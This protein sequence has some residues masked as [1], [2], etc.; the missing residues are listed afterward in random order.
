MYPGFLWALAALAIPLILHLFYFRRYKKVYFSN[1]R[2]LR[3]VKEETSVRNR[4]RNL[5][6]LLARMLAIA[7]LV[8]AFAQP[9]IPVGNSVEK[10]PKAVSIFVDN[11]FSMQA[12]GEDLPLLDRARQ[13]AREIILAFSETD[14]FQV[15]TN[16]LTLGESK[17]LSRDEALSA[18]EDIEIS[19]EVTTINEVLTRQH[20]TV[21]NDFD[22]RLR[23]Y[24]LSDFQ[25]SITDI[26]EI[27]SS[28][29]VYLVP[30][31]SVQERN[32]SIDT[33][34][35]AEPVHIINQTSRIIVKIMNHSDD[36]IENIK[37]TISSNGQEKPAATLNIE[38]RQ[39]VYDT[40][41]VSVLQA[42]WH[43]ATLRITDFPVQ[44]DDAYHMTFYVK[45]NVRIL[46]IHNGQLNPRVQAAFANNDQYTLEEKPVGNL[47]Y[48]RF[49]TYDMIILDEVEGLSSG[50][51][52]ALQNYLSSGG[53]VLFFP[54]ADGDV[55]SY[56]QLFT[57]C[58]A[59][60]FGAYIEQ[61]KRTGAIN[62]EA[63][64]FRNVFVET[65]RNLRLPEVSGFF[66]VNEIQGRGGERL[67]IYRDG[68]PYITQ[69]SVD[70]GHLVVANAPASEAVS[71]LTQNAEIFIPLLYNAALLSDSRVPASY[72]IGEQEL[73]EIVLPEDNT[74]RV[75]NMSGASEFIPAIFPA[76]ARTLVDPSGQTR[77][78]GF[79][80]LYSGEQLIGAYAFNYDRTESD[81]AYLGTSEL[82]ERYG[83]SVS[84]ISSQSLASFA[85]A[86]ARS[87]QGITLW[88]WCIIFALAFLGLE[89]LLIRVWKT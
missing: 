19:P 48:D 79:Y 85:S 69:F 33:A 21:P 68:S 5:L 35:F 59:N 24:L 22:G 41:N 45:E 29:E 51:A 9:F 43:E 47:S 57:K 4:L 39:Y 77:E 84:I 44:F 26:E 63:D 2:F 16:G 56:N 13:R 3:E 52:D 83:N 72:T 42:G 46:G 1:V 75:L 82:K 80:S 73:I 14:R 36:D 11:S 34:W 23:S 18:L 55:E 27:D 28:T 81:L 66:V 20:R 37:L 60:T 32:I 74:E 78:A 12:F 25:K 88:R 87:E 89:I 17:Y 15:L 10:G 31:Q 50:L 54:D 49:R 53:N 7:F 58:R 86:V 38:S 65:R 67:L 8:F 76:G 71:G 30:V 64:I 6:I 70:R 40:V 62:T 61:E